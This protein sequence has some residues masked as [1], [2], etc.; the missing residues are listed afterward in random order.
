ERGFERRATREG[1]AEPPDLDIVEAISRQMLADLLLNFCRILISDQPH[2]DTCDRN[3]GNDGLRTLAVITT[4]D[5][6]NI[7]GR[8]DALAPVDFVVLQ[9]GDEAFEATH[10]LESL[11][12]DW[13]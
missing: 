8:L 4:L 10:A 9:A 7:A 13:R 3:R 1:M 11:A 5:A 6:R 2:V 12:V